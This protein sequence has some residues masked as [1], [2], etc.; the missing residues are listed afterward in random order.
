[1]VEESIFV[2]NW[3]WN[4]NTY[5]CV[6]ISEG[7]DPLL[8]CKQLLCKAHVSELLHSAADNGLTNK[9]RYEMKGSFDDV[10]HSESQGLWTLS[11]VRNFKQLENTMFGNW[12]TGPKIEVSSF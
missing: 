8:L 2:Q 12:I 6:S 1:M 5:E 10:H 4:W 11:F 7:C 3:N 9:N